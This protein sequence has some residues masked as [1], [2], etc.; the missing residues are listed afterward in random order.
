MSTVQVG[1]RAP[2]FELAD[3]DG[4]PVSLAALLASGP[5]VLYFYPQDDTPGCTREACGFRDVHAEFHDAGARVVGVSGDSPETHRRFRE[6]HGLPFSLLADVGGD[7]RCAFGVP[8]TL[9]LLP[10]RVT[11]VIDREGIVRHV[12][13]S[14]LFADRHVREALSTVRHLVG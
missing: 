12:F 10:G 6:R 2:D 13:N 14:Q 5:L 1:D 11:Y 3:H 7:L 4:Q 8:R 9:G